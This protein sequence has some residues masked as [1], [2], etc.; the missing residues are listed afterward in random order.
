MKLLP[1][2]Q[3]A[4]LDIAKLRDYSL[5]AHH[6]RGRHKARQFSAS[7]GITAFDADWLRLNILNGLAHSEAISQEID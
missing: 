6:P 3:A 2:H 5:S 4:Q 7:L 1:N